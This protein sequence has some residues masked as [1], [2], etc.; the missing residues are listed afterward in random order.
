MLGHRGPAA[1]QPLGA[2]KMHRVPIVGA[3]LSA[4]IYFYLF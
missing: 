3:G 4:S 2:D 1:S